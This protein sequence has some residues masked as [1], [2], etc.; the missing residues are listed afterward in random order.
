[1]AEAL[2]KFIERYGEYSEIE[3]SEA[4]EDATRTKEKHEEYLKLRP[5][6]A[7][8]AESKGMLE[9]FNSIFLEDGDVNRDI[10]KENSDSFKEIG[11]DFYTKITRLYKK[12]RKTE[13]KSEKAS[14]D[15]VR[16]EGFKELGANGF[17]ENIMAYFKKYPELYKINKLIEQEYY[18]FNSL[19]YGVNNLKDISIYSPAGFRYRERTVLHNA[20]V[21]IAEQA[22]KDGEL[23]GELIAEP[24]EPS[25]V[26]VEEPS[27]E[28]DLE[29]PSIN[30]VDL[31]I[32]A[33]NLPEV[34]NDEDNKEIQSD[35]VIN[36]SI[37]SKD[38][39]EEVE[40]ED[41]IVSS[42][43]LE[44][45]DEL[46]DDEPEVEPEVEPV[47]T[48]EP[49]I[50]ESI[51]KTSSDVN[52]VY[53]TSSNINDTT[54][55]NETNNVNNTTEEV[56]S[57]DS[58]INSTESV[59]N[60]EGDSNINS[61]SSE[62]TSSIN[63]PVTNTEN[64]PLLTLLKMLFGIPESSINDSSGTGSSGDIENSTSITSNDSEVN[65]SQINESMS[66]SEVNTSQINESMS[67]S[68]S[69]INL[70]GDSSD[71]IYNDSILNSNMTTEY[72]ND[73]KSSKSDSNMTEISKSSS[74][75][76][77]KNYPISN[78]VKVT[79]STPEES[80]ESKSE[81]S[82]DNNKMSTSS[83]DTVTETTNNN[84]TNSNENVQ[85]ST[86]VNVDMSEV[87]NRLSRLEHIMSGPLDVKIVN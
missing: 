18:F 67:N 69:N 85:N 8:I 53:E 21:E 58:S 41:S 14:S 52:Q 75:I 44:I 15:L 71:N 50:N 30:D 38:N 3:I 7:D 23:E 61:M 11:P 26:N 35:S 34:L 54:N 64:N 24:E 42:D 20:F 60:V 29:E 78:P 81:E 86:G 72:D 59:N 13:R 5:E 70:Q 49:S 73:F 57:N 77:T 31:P 55:V 27:D 25:D 80:I 36:S 12:L 37:N 79:E 10:Y 33:S 28:V 76:D 32:E 46:K 56:S 9:T 63:S 2:N 62:S 39:I 87:V 65:T 82:M 48:S 19:S 51:P 74:K 40:K 84:E 22:K 66:D 4:T 47:E 83:T 1:M 43:P 6:L 17:L 16:A 68:E 45:I